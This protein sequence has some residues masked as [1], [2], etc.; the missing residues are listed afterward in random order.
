MITSIVHLKK[1]RYH[2]ENFNL[3][4]I[5]ANDPFYVDTIREGGVEKIQ[6]F[7]YTICDIHNN[8]GELI[9]W[10]KHIGYKTGDKLLISNFLVKEFRGIKQ[11]TL[12][13]KS[14]IKFI[15]F[16]RKEVDLN[17]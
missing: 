11:L 8:R 1:N 15:P 5:G 7:K 6:L 12:I 10:G 3:E 17:E 2:R 9:S 14:E 4:I 16:S 13:E